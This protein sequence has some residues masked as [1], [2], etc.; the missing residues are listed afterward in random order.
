MDIFNL[1]TFFFLSLGITFILCCLL[2]YHFK[3]RL[4]LFEQKNDT[5]F[6]IVNNVLSEISNIK[7]KQN[8][9]FMLVKNTN[10][11]S[12]LATDQNNNE[13]ISKEVLIRKKN[14]L[15]RK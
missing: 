8:V 5:I 4:D 10:I 14:V 13:V 6:E 1:G 7:Q 15:M 9:L 3:R 2:V 11:P 12:S